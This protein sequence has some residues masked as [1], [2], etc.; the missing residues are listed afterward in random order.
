[1]Q[2]DCVTN[3]ITRWLQN[4]VHGEALYNYRRLVDL[5]VLP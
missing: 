3:N 5:A 1:M 2:V 4:V